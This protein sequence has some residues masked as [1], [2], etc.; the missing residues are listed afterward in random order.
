MADPI[1]KKPAAGIDPNIVK[2]NS[3]KVFAKTVQLAIGTDLLASATSLN[4]KRGNLLEVTPLGIK[5]R[6][7]KSGRVILIPWT[8]IRAAE[9][10]PDEI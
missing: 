1:Q 2:S 6:S 3:G 5:A 8:N 10:M 4:S 7:A 9:L